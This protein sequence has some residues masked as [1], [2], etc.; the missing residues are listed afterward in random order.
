MVN[1]LNHRVKNSL[2][3][4]QSIAMQTLRGAT[5]P[6]AARLALDQRICSLARAHD[7]LTARNR[8]GAALHDVVGRAVE[9]FGAAR[10]SIAGPW[11]EVSPRYALALSMALHEL[12][13]NA[14]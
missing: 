10:F 4:V 2:A 12:A 3:T 11:L 14:A 5:D 9:P 8:V 13:T 1:E 7:L 6:E